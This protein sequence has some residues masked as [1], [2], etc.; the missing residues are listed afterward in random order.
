[1]AK[2]EVKE[3]PYRLSTLSLV[4]SVLLCGILLYVALGM[5][6]DYDASGYIFRS[7][8]GSNATTQSRAFGWLGVMLFSSVLAISI[9]QWV[10]TR[11]N[12]CILTLTGTKIIVPTGLT[13]SRYIEIPYSAMTK[14]KVSGVG[15]TFKP[16]NELRI[17]SAGGSVVI[18]PSF[19]ALDSD[20]LEVVSL[21]Q[22]R[23][24]C[25]NDS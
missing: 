20:F 4:L 21:V 13:C 11:R 7:T 22:K 12:E 19:L 24:K 8:Y 23:A 16:T 9:I 25:S 6:T 1:M 15:F 14:V 17:Y 2:I 3:Y 10:A 18:R 5:A